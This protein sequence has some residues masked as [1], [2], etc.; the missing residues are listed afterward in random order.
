VVEV[1]G[2]VLVLGGVAT[3]NVA[4]FAANTEMHPGVAHFEALF[5][6]LAVRLHVLD[7]DLMRAGFTHEAP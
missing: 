7:L 4:A 3:A 1:L 6:A 2:G 5:A